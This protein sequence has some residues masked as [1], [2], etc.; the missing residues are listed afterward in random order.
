MLKWTADTT[1]EPIIS[2][3]FWENVHPEVIAA[4]VRACRLAL[5]K[6]IQCFV[7][8]ATCMPLVMV[9]VQQSSFETTYDALDF[10]RPTH[11]IILMSFRPAYGFIEEFM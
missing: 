8:P 2:W 6:I 3:Y 7:K 5:H 1:R 10:S 11:Y 9:D 4:P